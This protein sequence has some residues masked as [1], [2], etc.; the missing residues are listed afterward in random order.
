MHS[1]AGGT[2][3]STGRGASEHGGPPS[4][5]PPRERAGGEVKRPSILLDLLFFL[6]HESLFLAPLFL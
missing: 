4:S 1:G 2:V 5:A 6:T 3:R